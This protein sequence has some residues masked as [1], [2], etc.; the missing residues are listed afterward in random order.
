[1]RV[2]SITE[3]SLK[4]VDVR[5]SDTRRTMCELLRLRELAAAVKASLV[6]PEL[7]D[8]GKGVSP[9]VSAPR[10]DFISF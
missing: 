3:I 1:M 5:I 7:S 2:F 9:K 6:S 10:F 8:R 4:S